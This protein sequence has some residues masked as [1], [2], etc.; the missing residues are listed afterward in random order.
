SYAAAEKGRLS[1]VDVWNDISPHFVSENVWIT[2]LEFKSDFSLEAD[3]S[4]DP[5]MDASF[6]TANYGSSALMPDKEMA[7]CISIKGLHLNKS[8]E[9]LDIL[10]RLKSSEVL[11]FKWDDK[12]ILDS[13]IIKL[14]Q[15]TPSD[16]NNDYAAPFE[17]VIPLAKPL[18][19]N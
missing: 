18:K 19:L 13:Q 14:N 15:A 12:T 3:G 10:K 1:F 8:T 9:V 5:I 2:D 4:S 11:T 16:E 7:D 6:A 17:L